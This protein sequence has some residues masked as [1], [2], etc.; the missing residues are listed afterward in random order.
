MRFPLSI[1]LLRANRWAPIVVRCFLRVSSRLQRQR[2][3]CFLWT[4]IPH[5]GLG[6]AKLPNLCKHSTEQAV[7]KQ[8]ERSARTERIH[9]HKQLDINVQMAQSTE[10][11]RAVNPSQPCVWRKA[12]THSVGDVRRPHQDRSHM[13][14][15]FQRPWHH[16]CTNTNLPRIQNSFSF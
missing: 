12:F 13:S 16:S 10:V 7:M 14:P 11:T 2:N 3:M 15:F 1:P 4:A 6:K 5:H 9:T 8:Q